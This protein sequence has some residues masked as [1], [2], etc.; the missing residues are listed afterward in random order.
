MKQLL[1]FLFTAC[2][3]SCAGGATGPKFDL[4][5]YATE[6][7]GSGA[8]LAVFKDANG[9]ALAKGTLQ[10]GVRTGTWMSYYQNSNKIK[11]LTSYI[12]GAK[13]GVHI[14]LNDRG[15]IESLTEYKNDQLHGLS[16]KYTFGR[17]TEETNYKN[18]KIDGTFAVYDSQGKLQRKGELTNG[19]YHGKLQYFDD[20]GNLVMEYEYENGEKISGGI[21][22]K[23]APVE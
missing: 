5:G 15:Q 4:K 19:Q 12:N 22:E 7:I 17:P 14:N 23:Q 2:L 1:F 9:W 21:V 6:N 20:A 11:T 16:A 13:N 3:M 18:G 8:Q 10:N